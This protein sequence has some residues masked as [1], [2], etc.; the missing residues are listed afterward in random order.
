VVGLALAVWPSV[1]QWIVERVHAP[2]VYVD[3][4]WLKIRGRWQYWF[5]VLDVATELPVL[6]SLLPS[7]SPWACRWI[8]R[9]LHRLKQVP[10]VIMTDG[11]PAYTYLAPGAKHVL[12]R[13]IND[14]F[15]TLQEWEYVKATATMADLL[16]P[17]EAAA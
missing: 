3:E 9:Q 14:P 8:G 11:L 6:A 13:L 4:K 15:R 2:M 10:Q 16:L 5:V 1:S 12:Y 17:Q 7:R